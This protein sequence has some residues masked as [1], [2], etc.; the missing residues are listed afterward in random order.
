MLHYYSIITAYRTSQQTKTKDRT[1]SSTPGQT[2]GHTDKQ[3][4]IRSNCTLL[5]HIYRLVD[6]PTDTRQQQ[7]R[8]GF[9]FQSCP[10]DADPLTP[11]VRR[12][13]PS[14]STHLRTIIVAAVR[15]FRTFYLLKGRH[16][17]QGRERRERG[18]GKWRGGVRGSGRVG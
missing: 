14:L 2:G 3:I 10:L 11:S 7:K 5:Y 9:R 16:K 6:Q 18:S 12:P 4:S 8:S 15:F 17:S 1:G 13:T